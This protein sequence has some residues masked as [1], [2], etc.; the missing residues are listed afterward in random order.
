MKGSIT[1]PMLAA[2]P[3]AGSGA[4]GAGVRAEETIKLG[5]SVPLSGAGAIGTAPIEALQAL[6]ERQGAAMFITQIENGKLVEK[7]RLEPKGH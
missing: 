2:L 7:A 5:F 1:R 3:V 4:L 6:A